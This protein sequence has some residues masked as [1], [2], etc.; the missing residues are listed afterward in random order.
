MILGL[1]I[2]VKSR[3]QYKYKAPKILVK[4]GKVNVKKTSRT[5]DTVPEDRD[6]C[7]YD[8]VGHIVVPLLL[9]GGVVPIRWVPSAIPI[10]RTV[11]PEP[12]NHID[13]IQA[14]TIVDAKKCLG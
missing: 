2:Q 8:L 11:S 6:P 14:E 12:V 3:M 10:L 5:M 1:L 9:K 7:H 4:G 13:L